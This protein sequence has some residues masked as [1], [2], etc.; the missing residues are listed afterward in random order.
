M[1]GQAAPVSFS[2]LAPGL[3]GV[4]QV[5]VEVPTLPPGTTQ[6]FMRVGG[7]ASPPVT[8]EIGR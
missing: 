8:M 2:G 1:G 4:Y 5:N 6:I 3:V 7:V